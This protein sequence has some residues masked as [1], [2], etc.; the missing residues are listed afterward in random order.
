MT[1]VLLHLTGRVH[2]Q[3][4][5]WYKNCLQ[6]CKISVF[7]DL[8]LNTQPLKT[9][10][11]FLNFLFDFDVQYI[12]LKKLSSASSPYFTYSNEEI[13]KTQKH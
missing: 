1:L 9:I 10:E 6:K 2:Q 7:G 8:K 4:K 3:T 12:L 13:T 5:V 11:I